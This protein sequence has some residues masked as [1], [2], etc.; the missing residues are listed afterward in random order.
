[1]RT[2]CALI[3]LTGVAV[4][5]ERRPAAQER[6]PA[7]AERRVLELEKAQ[8]EGKLRSAVEMRTTTGAPYSGEATTEFMQTLSDGNRITRKSVVRIY[9]DAEGR[10]RRENVAADGSRVE[11]VTIVD[12]VAG[13]TLMLDPETRTAFGD[14]GKVAVARI[15]SGIAGLRDEERRKAELEARIEGRADLQ[16]KRQIEAA[17][18]AA[19]PLPPPPPPP[20]GR[21]GRLARTDNSREQVSRQ[22]LGQ[23]SIDGVNARGSRT[24]TVIAAGAIGNEQPIRIVSEE[25]FSPDLQVLVM[26]RH[27]DP[28]SGETTYTLSNIVRAEPDR[29]LFELPADYSLKLPVKRELRSRD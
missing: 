14:P 2:L 1:M 19:A 27:N 10:V 11:S 29:S 21:G 7:L 6:E 12:P 20:M 17:A 3:I 4:S 13:S 9:R 23:R 24:T 25:W 15:D 5:A 18:R 22:D 8:L 26:T 16:S 28:R